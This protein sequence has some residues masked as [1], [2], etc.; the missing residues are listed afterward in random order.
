MW[1]MCD[2]H[3]VDTNK[4]GDLGRESVDDAVDYGKYQQVSSGPFQLKS[5]YSKA[6]GGIINWFEKSFLPPPFMLN[7]L[8]HNRSVALLLSVQL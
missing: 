7:H 2:K 5:L 1:Q 4:F 3:K 8:S 6:V